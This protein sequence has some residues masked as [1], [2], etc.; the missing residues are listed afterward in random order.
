MKRTAI[1]LAVIVALQAGWMFATA[2]LKEAQLKH[3]RTVLLETQ[4]VDPRDYLRG[5]YVIL[6]YKISDITNSS[7]VNAP[8]ATNNLNRA[9]PGKSV[10][11]TLIPKGEF[12][13]ADRLYFEKPEA[14]PSPDAVLM[15]GKVAPELWR[16]GSNSVHVYYGIE[17]YF[18]PEKTGFARGKMTVRVAL[19]D[20]GEALIKEVLVD[21]K[22]YQDVAKRS[23]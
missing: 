15:Q 20:Q 10:Y 22:P 21:G 2:L 16:W 6:N 12:Y 17:K 9:M 19:N 23:W 18:V 3:G 1:Y 11:V 4:S 8:V 13:V 14:L 7:I 5:D